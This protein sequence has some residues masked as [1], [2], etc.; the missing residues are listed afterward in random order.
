MSLSPKLLYPTVLGLLI[1]VAL[2]VGG[3][4]P[5][6]Q[7]VLIAGILVLPILYKLLAN[8]MGLELKAIDLIV[9]VVLFIVLAPGLLLEI[10]AQDAL[11]GIQTGHSSI[12]AAS[13]H[14][15]VALLVAALLRKQFPQFY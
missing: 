15:L 3:R 6:L 14:A 13:V 12:P 1:N 8:F 11:I 5:T 10:P 2:V 9:P 7:T 4:A